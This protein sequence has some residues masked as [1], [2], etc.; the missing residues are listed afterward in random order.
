MRLV[1]LITAIAVMCLSCQSKQG[2]AASMENSDSHKVVVKEVLQVQGYTYLKVSENGKEG[3]LATTPIEA[4]EGETYYYEKGFEMT[5][6]KSKELNKTFESITFLEGVSR[7]PIPGKKS[8][9]AVSPGSSRANVVKEEISIVPVEGGISISDLFSG[10]KSYEGKTV[11]IK[12]KVTKFS[13]A[14]MGT[15]WIH[16]QDG[17]ASDGNFDLTV[18]SNSI[19]N[20]GDTVIF[21]GKITLNKDLGYGYFFEV[22]ME[23]AVVL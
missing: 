12:G 7:E 6:F 14:I 11:K 15:N 18:T 5:N 3:W 19:V 13:P 9:K 17:T 4:K 16:V 23:D 10:K 20:T 22:L 21:E 8:E 2:P 1:L